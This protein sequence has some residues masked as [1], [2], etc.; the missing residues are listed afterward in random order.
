M[1]HRGVLLA[2]APVDAFAEQ[3]GVPV[4]AGVLL[5]HVHKQLAQR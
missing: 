3:V 1:R 2:D 5:G 4:V